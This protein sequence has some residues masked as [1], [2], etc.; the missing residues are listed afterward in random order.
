MERGREGI[1]WKIE[2]FSMWKR[3]SWITQRWPTVFNWFSMGAKQKARSV[4]TVGLTAGV[5]CMSLMQTRGEK[6]H[7]TFMWLRKLKHFV[8]S[9]GVSGE[10]D[11]WITQLY[12]TIFNSSFVRLVDEYVFKSF[13]FSNSVCMHPESAM[14]YHW[15]FRNKNEQKCEK[16]SR[17]KPQLWVIFISFCRKTAVANIW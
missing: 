7:F 3:L 1:K 2:R 13:S 11:A 5:K 12:I 15:I 14:L 16:E 6:N 17:I 8:S 4:G 9:A 10:F